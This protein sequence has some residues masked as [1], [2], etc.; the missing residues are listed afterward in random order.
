[1]SRLLIVFALASLLIAGCAHTPAHN[2][3]TPASASQA[4]SGLVTKTSEFSFEETVLRLESALEARG[5]KIMAK[6]DHA[7][8]A[9]N[10]DLI[11]PP[12]TLLIF[13]NPKAGTLLMQ[14][15]RSAAIDLP[16]KALV[17]QDG[18]SIILQ[19]ND[20][21]H[22]AGRHNIPDDAPVLEKIAGLL[23]SVTDEATTTE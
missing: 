8:N 2:N 10:V 14:T 7:A 3:L 19:Y 12:T 15:S 13:G 18:D 5:V 21:Y 17:T 16:M 11:L 22:L 9:A 4:G 20:I 23:D 1:M 6:I